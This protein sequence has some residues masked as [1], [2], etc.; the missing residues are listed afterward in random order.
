MGAATAGNGPRPAPAHFFCSE[1]ILSS[2]HRDSDSHGQNFFDVG[3]AVADVEGELREAVEDDV[4]RWHFQLP[5]NFHVPLLGRIP[6]KD[7]FLW[8][9]DW[10]I[11]GSASPHDLLSN[12]SFYLTVQYPKDSH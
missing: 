11:L 12:G 3:E 5:A 1:R 10:D 7:R 2:A 6:F 8:G 9:E 4:D